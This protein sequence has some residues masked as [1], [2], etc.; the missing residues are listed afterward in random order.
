MRS[1]IEGLP[2]EIASQIHPDWRR[3]E[4]DYWAVHDAL[5]KQYSGQWVA[6][7]DGAVI[8]FGRRAALVGLR[9]SDS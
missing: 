8:A 5:I 7:A 3:N 9:A 6:F 4:A 2:P 1:I